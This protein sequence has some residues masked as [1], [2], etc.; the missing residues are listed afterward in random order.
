MIKEDEISPREADLNPE[1][2][3]GISAM[4]RNSFVW[5]CFARKSVLDI[6][7]RVCLRY[8]CSQALPYKGFTCLATKPI[9]KSGF[10]NL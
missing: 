8:F 9:A 7:H 1:F 10:K 5:L 2:A 6:L 4:A 3:I